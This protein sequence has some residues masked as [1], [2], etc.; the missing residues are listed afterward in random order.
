MIGMGGYFG[1]ELKE[2]KEYHTGAVKLNTGRNC[3]AYILSLKQYNKVYL[4]F[5]SCDAL[6][7]VIEKLNINCAFYHVDANLEPYFDFSSIKTDE[8]FLYINYFGLKDEYISILKKKCKNLLIDNAQAFFSM[9]QYQIDTFYSPRKFFGL[10]DGAYLYTNTL[11]DITIDQDIS[12]QRFNHLL[13]RIDLDAEAGYK[14]FQENERL[15]ASKPI[16]QMS[17]LTNSILKSIDYAHVSSKRIENYK[18]IE[19]HL[20]N[21]NILN[22]KLLEGQVPLVYPFYS[23]AANLRTKLIKNKIFTAQYW[24]N[25]LELVEKDTLEYKLVTQTVHL[26]IDQRYSTSDLDYILDII[27]S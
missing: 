23:N 10:P 9:P 16:L 11:L 2:G 22:L 27:K 21:S 18:Y 3:L 24:P 5:Y 26:P 17:V 15:L 6:Y 13:Q 1:I 19:K 4:P 20:N 14:N 25:V 8:L 12:Y 7:I